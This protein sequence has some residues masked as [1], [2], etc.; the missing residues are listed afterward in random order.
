LVDGDIVYNT[1][2][3]YTDYG[4]NLVGEN[5]ASKLENISGVMTKLG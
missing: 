4:I 2:K 1:D 5:L 3:F